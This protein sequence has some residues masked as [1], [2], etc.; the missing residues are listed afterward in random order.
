MKLNFIKKSIL[1]LAFSLAI[2]S[3]ETDD[4]T[5]ESQLMVAN[6]TANINLEFANPVIFYEADGVDM[7][8]DYT[9]SLSEIQ[10]VD[11]KLYITQV[12][13][14]ADDNDFEMT[15]I[16]VI[17]AGYTTGNGSIT[18]FADEDIEGDE[19]AVIQIG[20]VRTANAAMTPVT[21]NINIVDYVFCTWNLEGVD[22]YGDGWNGASIR[23]T[24]NGVVTDFAVEGAS[25]QW[26]VAVDVGAAYSFEFISGDWDG[27][28][29][30][31]L[32]GPDGTVYADA[33]YPAVG[34]ITSGVSACD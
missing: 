23:L 7:T 4:Q 28:I 27:E 31:T 12:G 10:I 1:L 33:Y 17:P 26:A 21:V 13:G 30:Y 5:G 32:T 15:S 20:D 8:Y 18:V 2:V 25:G 16:I 24:N 14:T 3:C 6:T 22:T 34:V 29:E 9:V 19:T 11:I